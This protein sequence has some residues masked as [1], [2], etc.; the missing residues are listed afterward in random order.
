MP[1]GNI[2]MGS[3]DGNLHLFRV[4]TEKAVNSELGDTKKLTKGKAKR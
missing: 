4:G 2:L 1:N 3:F